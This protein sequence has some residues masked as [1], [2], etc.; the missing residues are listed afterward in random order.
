[1]ILSADRFE[2]EKNYAATMHIAENLLSQ[3]LITKKEYEKFRELAAK[4]YNPIF[5]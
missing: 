2:R 3:K 1:M 5:S 4:K